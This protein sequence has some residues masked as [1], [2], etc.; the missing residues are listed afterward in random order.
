MKAV[1]ILKNGT[2]V[3]VMTESLTIQKTLTGKIKRLRYDDQAHFIRYI[4]AKQIAC[5]L[6][7]PENK[8]GTNDGK[9]TN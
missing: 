4:D 9:K 8:E 5:V 7:Y 1:I 2:E 6:S 3:N